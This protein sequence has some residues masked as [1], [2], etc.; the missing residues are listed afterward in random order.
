MYLLVCFPASFLFRSEETRST[1]EFADDFPV[2]E[3]CVHFLK[4]GV[5]SSWDYLQPI[6]KHFN[7]ILTI[8][9]Y[10]FLRPVFSEVFKM[11][12]SQLCFL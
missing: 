10:I 5:A 6:K 9:Y 1:S 4:D 8:Y 11:Y 2:L 7:R 12:F 3:V